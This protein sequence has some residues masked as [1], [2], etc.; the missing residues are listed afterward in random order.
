LLEFTKSLHRATY[1][2]R[3]GTG[4]GV[5]LFVVG[6]ASCAPTYDSATDTQI[7]SVTQ[8][9][10]KQFVALENNYSAGKPSTHDVSPYNQIEGDLKALGNRLRYSG[11]SDTQSVAQF[12]DTALK[13]IEELRVR[14][15]AGKLPTAPGDTYLYDKETLF[16]L[17]MGLLTNY[18]LLLKGGSSTS[19]AAKSTVSNATAASK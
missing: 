18:E 1:R 17:N 8:E 3:R 14:H 7:T 12:A 9:G 15:A 6:L 2:S 19:S 5:C 16:N 4:L 11:N 10:D 13:Q